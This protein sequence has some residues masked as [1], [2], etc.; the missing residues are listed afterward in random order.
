MHSL[1]QTLDQLIENQP[2]AYGRSTKP[3][4]A[5][6]EKWESVMASWD[7][8]KIP[9]PEDDGVIDVLMIGNSFCTY[10]TE[11]LY[12]LAAAAGVKMRVCNL[13]Y[14]GCSLEQ[15]Y[16]W[17]QTDNAPYTFYNVDENGRVATKDVSLEWALAQGEW[18][19]L[20]IQEVS[21][22]LRHISAEEGLAMTQTYRDA[23]IPYL[24]ERFPSTQLYWHQTWAYQKGYNTSSY[25][26]LDVE[27]QKTYAAR[28]EA[29]SNAVCA[30]YGIP[31]V[32]SGIAW[33]IIR[34]GGYDEMC[35]RLGK[36]D[37][38]DPHAGD[39]YHDGD[40]GGGQYLNACVWF[41]MITG[42]SVVGNTYVPTYTYKDT[43]YG[44][45]E[46]ITVAEL[47]AAAHQAVTEYRAGQN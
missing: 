30:E 23:L 8:K 38:D 21:S 12:N 5:F 45:N 10:F 1:L 22:R 29:F 40:I 18:D 44:L 42:L 16:T 41:E 24:Q 2:K 27:T 35:D 31:K 34:D 26:C 32:P 28:Q 20:S 19:I 39:Y 9:T 4:R 47:Q 15:H 25:Q 11:E 6:Y 36:A 13:Y 3:A 17:W 43:V 7:L 33:E 14:G 37:G 46:E